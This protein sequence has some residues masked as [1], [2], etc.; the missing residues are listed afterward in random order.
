MRWEFGG[1]IINTDKSLVSAAR[2]KEFLSDSY[3]A[4]DRT[5]ELIEKTIE[6]SFCYGIYYGEE[7]VGFARVVTDYS[8]MVWISDVYIDRK[9]R[10]KGL[11]KKLIACILET[12]DFKNV[13]SALVTRDAH[14]LYEQFGFEGV[15]SVFMMRKS[16]KI[17]G[18]Y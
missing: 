17:W 18:N 11:G 1:Y 14:G 12:P 8:T 3:W 15:E 7:Q 10:R 4:A 9:H 5:K 6:H 16:G 2:V 13:R